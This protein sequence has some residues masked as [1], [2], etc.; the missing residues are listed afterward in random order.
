LEKKNKELQEEKNKKEELLESLVKMEENVKLTKKEFEE[1][2]EEKR[3]IDLKTKN[4]S[5]KL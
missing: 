2:E 5:K 4:V 1:L 3:L